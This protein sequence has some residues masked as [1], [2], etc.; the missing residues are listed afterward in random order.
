MDVVRV[1]ITDDDVYDLLTAQI[2][3]VRFRIPLEWDLRTLI[4]SLSID[5]SYP[6]DIDINEVAEEMIYML[7]LHLAEG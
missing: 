4:S 3:E 5:G 2:D 7:E 6:S 1:K